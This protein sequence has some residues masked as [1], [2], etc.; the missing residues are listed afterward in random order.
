MN[1]PSSGE[2]T[3]QPQ[4]TEAAAGADQ[5]KAGGAAAE[6]TARG[7]G[8]WRGGANTGPLAYSSL[9][10][11]HLS[12]LQNAS[13]KPPPLILGRHVLLSLRVMF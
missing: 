9:M 1:F 8:R 5:G 12:P 7:G 11:P 10:T 6:T 3:T 4:P 2:L 13:S